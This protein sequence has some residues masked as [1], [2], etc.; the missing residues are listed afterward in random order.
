MRNNKR[1][2]ETNRSSAYHITPKRGNVGN[3]SSYF[4]YRYL[5][6]DGVIGGFPASLLKFRPMDNIPTIMNYELIMTRTSVRLYERV[7]FTRCVD[8]TNNYELCIT[9]YELFWAS[10]RVRPYGQIQFLRCIS[11]QLWIVNYELWIDQD[12]HVRASLREDWIHQ[13]RGFSQQLRIMHYA[14]WI[15]KPPVGIGKTKKRRRNTTSLH[16]EYFR[17]SLS[18]FTTIS[19]FLAWRNHH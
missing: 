12:T 11:Q 2:C 5:T 17:I 16:T 6:P 3:P 4:L 8:F 10:T 13:M 15:A 19:D 14:L 7:G 1:K 9:H 18:Y